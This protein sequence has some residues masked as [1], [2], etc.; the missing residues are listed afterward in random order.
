MPMINI[1]GKEYDFDL[2]PD[3]AKQAMQRIQFADAEVTRLN[4][5]VNVFQTA[6]AV[7]FQQLKESVTQSQIQMGSD[8]IKLG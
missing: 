2:L 6:R 8:T 7:Y 4:A 1:E 3:S 5:Q